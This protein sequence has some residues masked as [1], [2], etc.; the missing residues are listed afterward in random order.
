[1]PMKNY[2]KTAGCAILAAYM[3]GT[4]CAAVKENTVNY[5]T[6]KPDIQKIEQG[7]SELAKEKTR[8]E[9]LE[10][11]LKMLLEKRKE[12]AK[13]THAIASK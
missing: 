7:I 11:K 2:I 12:I 10:T 1:M 3:A 6:Q 8:L 9:S 4:G 13:N 5:I